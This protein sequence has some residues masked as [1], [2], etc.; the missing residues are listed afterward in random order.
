M[1]RKVCVTDP[2]EFKPKSGLWLSCKAAF[3]FRNIYNYRK[4]LSSEEVISGIPHSRTGQE[5]QMRLFFTS[6]CF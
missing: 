4:Y 5:W 2:L 3:I 6:G 1:E